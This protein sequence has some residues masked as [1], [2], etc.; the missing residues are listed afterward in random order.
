MRSS[1]EDSVVPNP[2]RNRSH[3]FDYT[4]CVLPQNFNRD[5]FESSNIPQ[6]QLHH[7]QLTTFK[8][9]ESKK[10]K[11]QVAASDR[12]SR[13]KKYFV[14]VFFHVMKCNFVNLVFFQP[15]A[16]KLICH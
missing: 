10:R 7:P 6:T 16:G 1:D 15:A 2:K 4:D 3:A 12:V 14:K 8:N 9:R 5:S 13:R 11:L